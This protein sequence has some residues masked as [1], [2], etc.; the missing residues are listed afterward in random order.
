MSQSL[1]V[2]DEELRFLD[3]QLP[4]VLDGLEYARERTI[5]DKSLAMRQ[6]L[7]VDATT[8]SDIDLCTD[9]ITK[10]QTE[11]RGRGL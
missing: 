9:M 7:A 5:E 6:L 2:S 1:E 11:M 3:R 10:V 4:A 8:V